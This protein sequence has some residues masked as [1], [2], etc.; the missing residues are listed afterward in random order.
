[1]VTTPSPIATTFAVSP[2]TPSWGR[3]WR[4]VFFMPFLHNR[5]LTPDTH[6]RLSQAVTQAEIGH[7]GEVVL[8][9]ENHLPFA[10]ARQQTCRDR[11]ID[12]FGLYRVWDT[13]ENT[14]VLVYLN[15]CERK[16]E[17]V[18]DRGINDHVVPSLWQALCDKAIT[19]IQQ[20]KPTE[21]IALL[22]EEIGQLLRQH[23]NAMQAI[24]SHGNELPDDMVYLR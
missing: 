23:A 19:G 3:F 12:L 9:V 16:L 20:D 1:M 15:L 6:Q 14:G 4:Q 8:I 11:A 24:D 5:W 22:L 21:S 7:N 18:A 13:A 2:P 17:I 10:T